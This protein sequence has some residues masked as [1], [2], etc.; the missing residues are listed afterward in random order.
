MI[1]FPPLVIFSLNIFDFSVVILNK[2]IRIN[3]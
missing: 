3:I 2:E 1:S